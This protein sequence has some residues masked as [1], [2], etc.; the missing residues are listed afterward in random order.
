MSRHLDPRAQLALGLL[1]LSPALSAQ[2]VIRV[3]ADRATIREALAAAKAD[4]TILCAPA[5]YNERLV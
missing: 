4:T 3:P 5:I 1:L 2:N